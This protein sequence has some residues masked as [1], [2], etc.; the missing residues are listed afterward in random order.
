MTQARYSQN[1]GGLNR[2][3]MKKPSAAGSKNLA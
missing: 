1:V 2:A 3:A